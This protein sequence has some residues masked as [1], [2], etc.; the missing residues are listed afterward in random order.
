VIILLL[1]LLFFCIY[2]NFFPLKLLIFGGQLTTAEN[3]RGTFSA[4]FIF[5]GQVSTAENKLF[6]ATGIRPPKIN[7]YFRLIF[8]G[9]Q[10]PIKIGVKPPKISYFRWQRP[11]FRRPLAA[12][13][14]CSCRNECYEFTFCT[15][16]RDD[17]K[18]TS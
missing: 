1:E 6:S 8:S 9:G 17:S 3:N 2:F 11:Y 5:G 12:K 14:N 7:G 18:S 4:A 10:R 15:Y 13:N 16:L